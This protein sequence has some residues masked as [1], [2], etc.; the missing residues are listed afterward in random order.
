MAMLLLDN[1]G[2]RTILRIGDC[3]LWKRNAGTVSFVRE[4]GERI[5][6]SAGGTLDDKVRLPLRT[7][8][9]FFA[10]TRLVAALA[11]LNFKLDRDSADLVTY[12]FE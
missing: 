8:T 7:G 10:L 2:A 1:S 11:G 6:V 12:R 3:I 5:M 9:D 4:G